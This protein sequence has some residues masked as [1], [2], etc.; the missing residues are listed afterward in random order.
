M[1]TLTLLLPMMLIQELM[2]IATKDVTNL[3]ILTLEALIAS[4][5]LDVLFSSLDPNLPALPLPHS[6][7][8]STYSVESAFIIAKNFVTA[9]HPPELLYTILLAAIL[10][11]PFIRH[12]AK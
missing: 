11:M 6:I 5:A 9:P 4:F 8:T 2:W 10:L 12:L 3:L 1:L 7:V